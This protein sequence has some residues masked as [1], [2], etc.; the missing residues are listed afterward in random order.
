MTDEQDVLRRVLAERPFD[1]PS[2]NDLCPTASSAAALRFMIRSGEI[3]AISNEVVLSASG[4]AD[5][6]VRVREYLDSSPTAT[7]S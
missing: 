4:F 2:K 5:A 3:I 7:V 1:P 6:T